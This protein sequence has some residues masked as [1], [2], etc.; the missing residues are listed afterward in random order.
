MRTYLNIAYALLIAGAILV[1]SAPYAMANAWYSVATTA[2]PQLSAVQGYA[3]FTRAD[4]TIVNDG[5]ANS[6]QNGNHI[7]Q[8]M[9]LFTQATPNNQPYTWI[10][11]GYIAGYNT[12]TPNAVGCEIGWYQENHYDRN[13]SNAW[14]RYSLFGSHEPNP[15]NDLWIRFKYTTPGGSSGDEGYVIFNNTVN[16]PFYNQYCCSNRIDV[17]LEINNP[18]SQAGWRATL[19]TFRTLRW[20]N[21]QWILNVWNGCSTNYLP[22]DCSS[23]SQGLTGY[24]DTK[25]DGY[26]SSFP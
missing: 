12:T 26:H 21:G 6:C 9:W 17:G 1:V 10:E 24:W 2:G 4:L 3:Q 18:P 23:Q 22:N 7:N 11:A 8:T 13:N 5:S 16:R 19:G 14:D 25:W 15:T 20:Y